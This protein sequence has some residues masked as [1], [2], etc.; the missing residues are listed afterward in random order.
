[1]KGASLAET[2]EAAL[3]E[4]GTVLAGV[5]EAE[6]AALVGEL[7]AARRVFCAGR[8]RSELQVRGFA[9]RLM[10][11]GLGCHVV[12]ETTTPSIGS[13]DVL[14]LA[15]GAAATRTL[16][17]IAERARDSGARVVLLTATPSGPLAAFAD[18]LVTIDAAASREDPAAPGAPLLPMGSR[19]ELSLAVLLEV[20]VIRLMARRSV[21]VAEMF[22]RHAN[23]E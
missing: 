8:G 11:L 1:V 7:Q 23:L 2:L 18:A 5:R 22:A 20:V 10:H 15:S 19:F 16:V 17:P 3:S 12:G 6:V 21:T 13:G 4:L 14:V 9:M